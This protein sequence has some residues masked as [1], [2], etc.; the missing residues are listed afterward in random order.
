LSYIALY[1]SAMVLPEVSL[2]AFG[3]DADNLAITI[4]FVTFIM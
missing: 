4:S 1:I 3:E 2:E